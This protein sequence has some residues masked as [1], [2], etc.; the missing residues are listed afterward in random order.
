MIIENVSRCHL[1]VILNFQDAECKI[2]KQHVSVHIVHKSFYK[3][4][5]I[6]IMC[7]RTLFTFV[8]MYIQTQNFTNLYREI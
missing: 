4:V 5:D 3:L 7:S 1:R 6:K 8:Y 2:L